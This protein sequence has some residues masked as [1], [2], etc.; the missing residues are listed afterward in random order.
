MLMCGYNTNVLYIHLYYK[1]L[2]H[3]GGMSHPRRVRQ[4]D[5]APSPASAGTTS[6]WQRERE[7]RES[8]TTTSGGSTS[9]ELNWAR[10]RLSE[11]SRRN[12]LSG[13]SVSE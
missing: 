12:V 13:F 10:D 2:Q 8:T 9:R 3:H 1:C 5:T 7:R 6:T 4:H 11:A